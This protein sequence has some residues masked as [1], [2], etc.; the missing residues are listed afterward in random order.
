MTKKA[1]PHSKSHR[2]LLKEIKGDVEETVRIQYG[3]KEFFQGLMIGIVFGFI[4]AWI[5]F[6]YV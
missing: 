4:L 6:K 5:L 2:D 3:L 1:K